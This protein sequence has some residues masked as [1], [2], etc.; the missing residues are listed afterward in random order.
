MGLFL[1]V[2]DNSSLMKTKAGTQEET[3]EEYC[4]LSCSTW[5]A[6]FTILDHLPKVG[7][8]HSGWALLYQSLVKQMSYKCAH[9]PI[10]W[11]QFLS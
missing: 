3:I 10:W 2:L 1:H 8:A 4:L 6:S 5:F 9:K 11:W 7:I